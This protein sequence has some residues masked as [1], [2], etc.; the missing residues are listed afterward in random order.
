MKFWILTGSV[1]NWE[2]GI[3]KKIWGARPSLKKIWDKI[4]VGD[5]LAFYTKS[6]IGGIIGFGRV[7]NKSEEDYPLWPDEI[8]EHTVKYPYRFRFSIEFSLDT[9]EWKSKK[10]FINDLRIPFQAGVNSLSNKEKISKLLTRASVQWSKGFSKLIPTEVKEI[11]ERITKQPTLHSDIKQMLYEI[12]MMEGKHP[13]KEFSMDSQVLDV[14]WKRI[15]KGYPAW[16]FEIQIG[17]DIYH[18]LTKL[19]H[20]FD[21]WG[22]SLCLVAK[23]TDIEKARNLLTGAFHE[24]KN[25]IEFLKP[26]DVQKW[27]E[28]QKADTEM[29]RKFGLI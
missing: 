9:N 3:S 2:T 7:E 27:Y 29:R 8:L 14:V 4:S 25:R 18:A 6:P 28:T 23:E 13:E 20:A 10:V 17:G 15:E 24:I 16:T 12:G 26:D 21:F 1:Q 19:K 5:V 22:S 11:T